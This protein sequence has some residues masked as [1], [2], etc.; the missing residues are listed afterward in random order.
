MLYH[1]GRHLLTLTA[2]LFN[3]FE[4]TFGGYFWP[5]W[6]S[7]WKKWLPAFVSSFIFNSPG[8]IFSAWHE[9]STFLMM[10]Y[11]HH[12]HHILIIIIYDDDGDMIFSWIHH[13]ACYLLSMRDLIPTF[14]PTTSPSWNSTSPWSSMS[15]YLI[16]QMVGERGSHSKA[17]PFHDWATARY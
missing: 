1:W 7:F 11:H 13:H 14:S 4:C 10:F 16:L 17:C 12:H 6:N 15:E 8:F 5:N 2:K 3:K 9:Q